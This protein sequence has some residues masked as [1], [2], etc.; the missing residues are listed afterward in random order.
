MKWKVITK[1]SDDGTWS[2]NVVVDDTI[3]SL[4]YGFASQADAAYAAGKATT[5]VLI[6]KSQ[7]YNF[8]DIETDWG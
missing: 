5:N 8:P 4:G 3:E 2:F 6:E 7:R 1:R